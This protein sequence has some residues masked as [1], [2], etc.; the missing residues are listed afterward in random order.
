MSLK[1]G[2]IDTPS[3]QVHHRYGGPDG[4]VP[5]VFLHQNTSSSKMF[6]RTMEKLCDSRKVIA[7]DLPGFG[8]T[9]DPPA[10]ES[11][12]QLTASMIE[13]IDCLEINEFHVCGQHI[14]AGI[15]AEMGALL[16]ERVRS[17]MMIGPFLL[18]KE[19]KESY[20][21]NFKGSAKPDK[22][23][24][25]L[26][27]TWNYLETNGAGADMDMFHDEFWQALRSWRARGMIYGCVWDYPFEDFFMRLKCPI[28]LMAA[29]D[30]VLYPGYL[31]AKEAR[32]EVC[33]VELRGSNFE[34][35]LDPDGTSGAIANFL[36]Q[37]NL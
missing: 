8:E 24:S 34:P 12:S 36:V 3:G 4:N 19:E 35:H 32:P 6:E 16:P 9:Y 29:P 31:R 23:A 17:A 14:G 27:E 26:K 25:Y 13:A 22:N 33:A 15:A 21:V 18:T 11:I 5:I 2:Y 28:L 7:L 20:R 10:F 1:K 37:E 30:D